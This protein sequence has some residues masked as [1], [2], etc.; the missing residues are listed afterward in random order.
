MIAEWQKGYGF[1]CLF[2]HGSIL[3]I[4]R[5]IWSYDNGNNIPEPSE[6]SASPFFTDSDVGSLD[7]SHPA[8]TFLIACNNGNPDFETQLGY[9]LLRQGAVAVVAA[10]AV[11]SS[12]PILGLRSGAALLGIYGTAVVALVVTTT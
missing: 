7:D 3:S 4:Y 8:I 10:T 1:S 9:A 5:T 12:R 2:G 6:L 11:G